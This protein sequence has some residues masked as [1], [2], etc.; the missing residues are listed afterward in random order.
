MLVEP[1][2]ESLEA[3]KALNVMY[4]TKLVEDLET[5]FKNLL[6]VVL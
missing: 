5:E 1:T 6:P 4:Y 2:P 3:L